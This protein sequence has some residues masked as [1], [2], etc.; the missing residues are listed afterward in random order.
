MGPYEPSRE[1]PPQDTQGRPALQR[2][3]KEEAKASEPLPRRRGGQQQEPKAKAEVT[4][5]AKAKPKAEPSAPK[6]AAKPK[7][8]S[9]Q[10]ARHDW[11]E[12]PM[13]DA[14]KDALKAEFDRVRSENIDAANQLFPNA[15]PWHSTSIERQRLRSETT[16]TMTADGHIATITELENHRSNVAVP[17]TESLVTLVLHALRTLKSRRG[18][19]YDLEISREAWVSASN[20]AAAISDDLPGVRMTVPRLISIVYGDASRRMQMWINQPRNRHPDDVRDEDFTLI[21]AVS[22][23]DASLGIDPRRLY[24]ERQRF[25]PNSNSFNFAG[26]QN[27]FYYTDRAGLLRAW[28]GDALSPDCARYGPRSNR[29]IYCVPTHIFDDDCPTACS[30]LYGTQFRREIDVQITI[31][32]ELIMKDGLECFYTSDGFIAIECDK[33]GSAY[34]KQILNIKNGQITFLRQFELSDRFWRD[35]TIRV[36]HEDT[37]NMRAVVH[38]SCFVCNCKAWLGTFTCFNCETPFMYT[39]VFPE[40]DPQE[41]G[42]MEPEHVA[43]LDKGIKDVVV[44]LLSNGR[45]IAGMQCNLL[46]GIRMPMEEGSSKSKK[47][48]MG[49]SIRAQADRNDKSTLKQHDRDYRFQVT[50]YE[51]LEDRIENDRSFRLKLARKVLNCSTNYAPAQFLLSDWHRAAYTAAIKKGE[52][53]YENLGGM[54]REPET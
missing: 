49:R 16:A 24:A 18:I 31:D 22:G 34:F 29:Y 5:K 45:K 3:R 14:E 28:K 23:H 46:F 1:V 2:I 48:V 20:L 25:D 53:L 26:P 38:E 9:R 40:F 11:E 52:I 35:R 8:M 6:A 4:P 13:T 19:S 43:Q 17:A 44:K 47:N 39:D 51:R 7:A 32:F 33:L 41:T 27:V 21:R 54:N 42:T 37:R 50:P 15:I 12:A 36:P 10:Q 30:H